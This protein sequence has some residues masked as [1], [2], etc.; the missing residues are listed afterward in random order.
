MKRIVLASVALILASQQVHAQLDELIKQNIRGARESYEDAL[1]VGEDK[2]GPPRLWLHVRSDNQIQVAEDI[3]NSLTDD[4]LGVIDV[5]S[6]PV[7]K[8]D[9]GPNES[10]LR[11][12]KDVDDEQVRQLLDELK[13]LIPDLVL[14]DLSNEYADVGWIKPGHYELWLSPDLLH[15]TPSE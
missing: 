15:V 1:D 12:F 9:F 5:E 6:L 7:Q 10:Q 4:D 8:V 11:Y 14:R 2:L 13:R 3:L